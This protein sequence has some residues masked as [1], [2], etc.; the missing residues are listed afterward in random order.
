MNN[1]LKYNH[2]SLRAMEP[3]DINLLYD[4]ENNTEIWEVSNTK[5]P[6]SKH[7]LAKYIS[8]SQGD[9][10]ELKQ[11]RLIIENEHSVPVGTIDLFDLD[12]YHQRAGLGI[13]I[14]SKSE[15]RKGYASDALA[16]IS[17]YCRN[18]IGIRQLFVNIGAMNEA[19]LG[20]FKKAGFE[21]TGTKK[22]WLKTFSGWEDEFFLQ[23]F[24]LQG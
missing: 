3:A 17:A 21:I 9:I 19:S 14:H 2:I 6:M 10:Y 20:L 12:P 16:A 15:R 1:F 4:W 7:I 24:L 13:L 18:V 23:K 22:Q 11:L 5:T 8:D